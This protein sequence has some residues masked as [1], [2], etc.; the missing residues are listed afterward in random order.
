MRRTLCFTLLAAGLALSAAPA[1]ADEMCFEYT[2]GPVLIG[3]GVGSAY[4]VV[5]GPGTFS[6]TPTDCL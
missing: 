5:Y 1:S 2:P 3:R 4:L 6:I